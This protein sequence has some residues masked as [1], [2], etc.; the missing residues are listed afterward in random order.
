MISVEA[1]FVLNRVAAPLCQSASFI[2]ESVRVRS[3]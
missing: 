2:F 3:E 1:R